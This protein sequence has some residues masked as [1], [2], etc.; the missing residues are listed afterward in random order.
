VTRYAKTIACLA[1]SRKL[2]GRCIAGKVWGQTPGPWIRPVSTSLTGEVSEEDRAYQDG[3]DPVVGDVI[4]IQFVKPV[5][6]GHQV[7]NHQYDPTFYWVRTGRITWADLPKL[8]DDPSQLWDNDNST[9]HGHFDRVPEDRAAHLG[10]SLYL[11]RALSPTIHV[12]APGAAFG[13]PKRKVRMAFTHRAVRYDFT[14][15]DPA[16]T[17]AYL[18]QDD[19]S[20]TLSGD[21][22]V[23]VSLGEPYQGFIYKLVAAVITPKRFP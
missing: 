16:V 1:N 13:D 20:Y 2:S 22:Y 18:A 3:T 21:V 9:Y 12:L 4:E 7:E 10:S 8:R 5:P 19:G 17:R 23:C 15:T 14:V 11:V 6:H